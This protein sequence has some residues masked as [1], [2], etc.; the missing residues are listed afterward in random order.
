[1]AQILPYVNA[2]MF[3]VSYFH[4]IDTTHKALQSSAEALS[5]LL[6]TSYS[7]RKEKKGKVLRILLFSSLDVIVQN[8]SKFLNIPKISQRSSE[9]TDP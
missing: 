1:M 3:Y 7:H 6:H 5:I 4:M 2:K 8:H 9:T